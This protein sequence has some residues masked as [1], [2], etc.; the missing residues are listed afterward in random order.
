MVAGDAR[1]REDLVR[2]SN[3]ITRREGAMREAA[4]AS[5]AAKPMSLAEYLASTQ[6]AAEA[7]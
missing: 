5:R 7:E 1:A 4:S 2:L 3:L 6:P